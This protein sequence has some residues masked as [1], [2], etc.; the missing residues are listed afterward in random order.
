MLAALANNG[1]PTPTHALTAGSVA[2]DNGNSGGLATDQRGFLRINDLPG[3]PNAPTG[4]GADIGAFEFESS[5][6]T[7]GFTV[8]GRVA[9]STLSR[10]GR[11]VVILTDAAGNTRT[12]SLTTHGYFRF[13]NVAGGEAYVITAMS[14]GEGFPPAVIYVNDD[15]SDVVIT[16]TP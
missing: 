10:N 7:A 4:D 6:N 2:I 13:D 1:G 16:A 3:I 9:G 5:A 12:A 14:K 15:V 8:S 11:T